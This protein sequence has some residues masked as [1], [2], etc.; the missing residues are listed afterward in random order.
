MR[1]AT[2][3]FLSRLRTGMYGLL[4]LLSVSLSAQPNAPIWPTDVQY[5]FNIGTYTWTDSNSYQ[6]MVLQVTGLPDIN[7]E[8][9][10]II[11]LEL[12]LSDQPAFTWQQDPYSG[13]YGYVSLISKDQT[14]APV[15]VLKEVVY[16][17]VS[18][19]HQIQHTSFF[20][21]DDFDRIKQDEILVL[22]SRGGFGY[23]SQNHMDMIDYTQGFRFD[24]SDLIRNGDQPLADNKWY[25]AWIAQAP[26]GYWDP[27]KSEHVEDLHQYYDDYMQ[28]TYPDGR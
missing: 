26:P 5:K 13:G 9:S 1:S 7:T 15:M 8:Y 28:S 19:F 12:S 20:L 17:S 24:K 21:T 14:F 27:R 11:E 6:F 25:A 23:V 22:Y 10:K 16:D 4:I 2:S 3:H 18:G